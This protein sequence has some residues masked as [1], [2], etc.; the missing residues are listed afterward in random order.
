MGRYLLYI[1]LALLLIIFYLGDIN[2]LLA[3]GLLTIPFAAG[4]L[5]ALW[6][7]YNMG[8]KHYSPFPQ[9]R[10]NEKFVQ[11]GLYKYIRHPMYTGVILVAFSLLLT[12]PTLIPFIVF[13]AL[14]YT[15]DEKA[16]LEEKLLSKMHPG[17]SSYAETTKKF[18][19]FVY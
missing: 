1:Q 7:F 15:L 6:A 17:Y 8:T 5:I 13:A 2:S 10:K 4:T 16:S 9:P 11:S 14:V 18:I 19:P 3:N 12:S